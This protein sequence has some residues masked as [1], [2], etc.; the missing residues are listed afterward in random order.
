MGS[1]W[2]VRGRSEEGRGSHPEVDFF[3][4][5]VKFKIMGLCGGFSLL[6]KRSEMMLNE[7]FDDIFWE[8]PFFRIFSGVIYTNISGIFFDEFHDKKMD[9]TIKKR[10]FTKGNLE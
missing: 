4:H 8:S 10:F 6:L 5:L 2:G 9:F 1:L 3:F 7:F